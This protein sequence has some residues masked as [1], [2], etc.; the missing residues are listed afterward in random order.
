MVLAKCFRIKRPNQQI[1][2]GDLDNQIDI[3]TRSILPPTGNSTNFGMDLATTS[4]VA[5]MIKTKEGE[6]IFGGVDTV[7]LFTHEFYIFFIPDVTF[8]LMVT[9][10]GRNYSILDTT[11]L[12]VRGQ[13]IRLRGSVLGDDALPPNTYPIG[14]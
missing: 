13:F 9:F 4:T 8:E 3:K 14:G 11:N 5:A 2:L 1:C 12:D 7:P 10:A 6:R